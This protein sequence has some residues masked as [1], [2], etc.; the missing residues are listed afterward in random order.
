MYVKY[1]YDFFQLI[2]S[3]VACKRSF[4]AHS[5]SCNDHFDWMV[6]RVHSHVTRNGVS[7][8]DMHTCTPR[9]ISKGE[10]VSN[11]TLIRLMNLRS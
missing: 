4:V 11:V 6:N 3:L 5:K 10:Q 7:S 1:G 2:G 9:H 8:D